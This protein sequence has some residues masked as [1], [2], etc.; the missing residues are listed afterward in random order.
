MHMQ[1]MFRK[2]Q[3]IISYTTHHL[4]SKH[5]VLRNA[6]EHHHAY[7]DETHYA[8]VERLVAMRGGALVLIPRL[9]CDL[10]GHFDVLATASCVIRAKRHDR[11][12]AGVLLAVRINAFC[13]EDG[14]EPPVHAF[15][16]LEEFPRQELI[17]VSLAHTKKAES[18][19]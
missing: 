9:L 1:M 10:R 4:E 6:V 8:A 17:K 3:A 5:S 2:Y 15:H 7:R 16:F 12:V 11:R 14:A 18:Q 19:A 13:V